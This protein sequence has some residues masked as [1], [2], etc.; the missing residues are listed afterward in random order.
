MFQ[1]II[2]GIVF[3]LL[4]IS[5]IVGEESKPLSG[6]VVD[7][8]DQPLAGATVTAFE[9]V[10]NDRDGIHK[11]E[12]TSVVTGVDGSFLF[13]ASKVKKC[14]LILARK[15][16]RCIGGSSPLAMQLGELVYRLGP[17]APLDGMIVDDSAK[18]VAGVDVKLSFRESEWRI[19]REAVATK[20][21]ASGHFRFSDLP[22]A[23]TF[24]LDMSAPGYARCFAEGPFAPRQKDIRFVMPPEGRIEGTLV[25]EETGKPLAE[26]WLWAMSGVPSGQ[27]SAFAKT[28]KAGQFVMR[29]LSGGNYEIMMEWHDDECHQKMSEWIVSAKSEKVKV[30]AG[31]ISSGVRVKAVRGG[32][33]EIG[34]TDAV[35]GLP[36]QC[37][38]ARVHIS[39]VDDLRIIHSGNP[40]EDGT[41][42]FCVLPGNYIVRSVMAI[43]CSYNEGKGKPFRVDIGKTNRIA[44]AVETGRLA[45]DKS[46]RSNTPLCNRHRVRPPRKT[47]PTGKSSRSTAHWRQQGLGCRQ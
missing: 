23:A 21:D 4:V 37:G 27:N 35:T 25:D 5:A 47:G 8:K 17:A 39:P 31:K 3:G 11:R 26:I 29:G 24:K 36:F 30:E 18:P 22:E 9:F 2:A 28:D 14:E 10:G 19:P 42:R 13:D 45:S 16:G 1:R 12:L 44:I 38:R 6:R 20:T 7:E 46:C 33:L 43:S 32:L 41:F 34:L 15:P 40:F